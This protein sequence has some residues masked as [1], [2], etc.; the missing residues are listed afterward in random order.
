VSVQ[1][2]IWLLRSCDHARFRLFTRASAGYTYMLRDYRYFVCFC[3]S[4]SEQ[5]FHGHISHNNSVNLPKWYHRVTARHF[6]IWRNQVTMC[7]VFYNPKYY[8][9][10]IVNL[11]W[12]STTVWCDFSILFLFE[13]YDSQFTVIQYTSITTRVSSIHGKDNYNNGI[14]V[15]INWCQFTRIQICRIEWSYSKIYYMVL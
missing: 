9:T 11:P 13:K 10:V 14:E 15:N 2:K 1:F 7:Q 4:S 6:P 5:C 12:T 8:Q 3:F